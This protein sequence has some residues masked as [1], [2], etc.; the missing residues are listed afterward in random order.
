RSRRC[1]GALFE[2][3]S[4]HLAAV[5]ARR[6]SEAA[7]KRVGRRI[8]RSDFGMQR[9]DAAPLAFADQCGHCGMADAVAPMSGAYKKVVDERVAS[10]KLHAKAHRYNDIARDLAAIEQ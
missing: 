6:K 4:Q 7:V 5:A 1:R 8:V 3:D 9:E 10:A 2:I